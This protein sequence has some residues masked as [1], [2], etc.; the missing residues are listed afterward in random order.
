MGSLWDSYWSLGTSLY[1]LATMTAISI[2]Y[3]FS[4]QSVVTWDLY[5]DFVNLKQK[6]VTVSSDTPIIW[7]NV[8]FTETS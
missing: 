1:S 2:Q 8:T 5:F 6:I 4:K 7:R 3:S